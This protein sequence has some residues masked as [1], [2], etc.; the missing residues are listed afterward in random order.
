MVLGIKVAIFDWEWGEIQPLEKG[1]KSSEL[2]I[3]VIIYQ[4]KHIL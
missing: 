4:P 3:N 1:R 2:K